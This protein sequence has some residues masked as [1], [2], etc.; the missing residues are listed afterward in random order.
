MS[1][2]VVLQPNPPHKPLSPTTNK[3]KYAR[4]TLLQPPKKSHLHHCLNSQKKHF[5]HRIMWASLGFLCLGQSFTEKTGKREPS[6][7]SLSCFSLCLSLTSSFPSLYYFFP[8]SFSIFFLTE[9]SSFLYFSPPFSLFLSFPKYSSPFCLVGSFFFLFFNI[10]FDLM[11]KRMKGVAAAMESS[12]YAILY[13]VQRTRL[14]HQSLMQDY[15]E[16]Y[17]ETESQK[18]KLEMMKQKRLTLLSE[19]RFLRQRYKFLMQNQSQNPAPAPKYIKKQ[20]LINVNRT[21]RKERNY[22]GNDAA[23]QCQA[24]QFD[25]NRKGKKVYSE[26]EAALQTAGPVFDLSQKQK[27]YIVKE[28]AL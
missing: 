24:P 20:N 11:M 16:L 19:V 6:H 3:M 15:E 17:R 7:L 1:S 25:L 26:R 9:L 21:V 2:N 8:I 5:F 23:V 10:V 18:R 22:T 4:T 28:A 13:E 12:P 27:T 14:K